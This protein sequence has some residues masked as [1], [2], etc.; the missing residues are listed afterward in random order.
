MNPEGLIK[1]KESGKDRLDVKDM[2]AKSG[3][4]ENY[5]R[6]AMKH[7]FLNPP[8]FTSKYAIDGVDLSGTDKER[9]ERHVESIKQRRGPGFTSEKNM[10]EVAANLVI[11]EARMEGRPIYFK[12]KEKSAEETFDQFWKS[13]MGKDRMN[14][15]LRKEIENM[16]RGGQ[17]Y[18]N[19]MNVHGMPE[20]Y[21]TIL[22]ETTKQ[23]A[24]RLSVLA[25]SGDKEAEAKYN[26]LRNSLQDPNQL[27]GLENLKV[28]VKDKI[29]RD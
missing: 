29:L 7:G 24:A 23:E 28:S 25:M 2:A 26:K 3:M 20:G 5:I 1:K 9:V 8:H 15:K 18:D 16:D 14:G 27:P 6:K 10:R 17:W 19:P 4:D 22:W 12:Y 21:E 11:Q 13:P